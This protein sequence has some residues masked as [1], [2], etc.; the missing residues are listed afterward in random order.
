MMM[1]V[2]YDKEKYKMIQNET[3]S[4]EI[5]VIFWVK[6]NLLGGGCLKNR[7]GIYRD[8]CDL[9]GF[10]QELLLA[11][12][13]LLSKGKEQIFTWVDPKK[14]KKEAEDRGFKV[15]DIVY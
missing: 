6:G 3:L 5:E 7:G 13:F 1:E 9:H 12:L 8:N 2:I 4:K 11:T 14:I 10:F 15:G